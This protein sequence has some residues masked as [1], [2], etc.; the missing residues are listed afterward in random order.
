[1]VRYFANCPGS[2]QQSSA[3]AESVSFLAAVAR[4][5]GGV[6]PEGGKFWEEA[7]I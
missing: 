3:K 7:A 2:S 1:M 6:A 5:I 4:D